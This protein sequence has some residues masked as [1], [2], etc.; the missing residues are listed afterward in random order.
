MISSFKGISAVDLK[1]PFPV[2][3][4]SVPTLFL[5]K[6][7]SGL[8]RSHPENV[9]AYPARPG[10]RPL[11][12]LQTVPEASRLR[13]YFPVSVFIPKDMRC[14][15]KSSALLVRIWGITGDLRWFPVIPLFDLSL[16]LRRLLGLAVMKGV[17]YLSMDKNSHD[18]HF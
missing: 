17:K 15:H 9:P 8:F 5:W 13:F 2:F 12:W 7:P 6:S 3:L 10:N 14:F 1:Q 4:L 18:M 16:L 11:S